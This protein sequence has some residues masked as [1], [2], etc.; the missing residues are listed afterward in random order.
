MVKLIAFEITSPKEEFELPL[1]VKVLVT[2]PPFLM[3]P[4][5][6]PLDSELKV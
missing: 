2:I 1:I 4:P 6:E 3:D 5:P